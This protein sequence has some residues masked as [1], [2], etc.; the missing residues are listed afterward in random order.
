ML[1]GRLAVAS[2]ASALALVACSPS[3]F[4]PREQARSVINADMQ[5]RFPGVDTTPVTDC[6][7]ENATDSELF[8]IAGSAVTGNSAT[9]TQT[10]AEII[11]R[12]PTLRCMAVTYIG[13]QLL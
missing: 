5:R 13:R 9:G 3:D 6:V 11:Q 7:I 8:A 1:V 4:D 10:I 2:V 12:P